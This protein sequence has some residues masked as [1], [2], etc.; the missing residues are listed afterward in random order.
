MN[1]D[2]INDFDS[3]I[4]EVRL[5]LSYAQ[6]NSK[7]LTRYQMFIKVSII[8]LVTKFE[9]FIEDFL[10][11]HSSQ[12][13]KGH[14]NRTLPVGM[15]Q[16]YAL[17]AIEKAN[18]APQAE[19]KERCIEDISLLWLGEEKKIDTLMTYR[20]AVKFKLGKHGQDELMRIFALNGLKDYLL[21]E[22]TKKILRQIDSL[23]AIRNNIIHEDASPSITHQ[24]VD[25][26]VDG[27]DK[28]VKD[29]YIYLQTN[30]AN[31]YNE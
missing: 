7:N 17:S 9:S 26:Y 21:L 8:L 18:Q 19:K 15:R 16:S 12:V 28:F 27:I 20:P 2:C 30:K 6:K 10:D 31:L 25:K 14:T 22:D 4:S 3:K 24:D 23:L 5:L 13:I 1:F 11:E 29:L